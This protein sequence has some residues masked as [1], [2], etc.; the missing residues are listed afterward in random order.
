MTTRLVCRVADAALKYLN[1]LPYN[2]YDTFFALKVQNGLRGKGCN[3]VGC[4]LGTPLTAKLF[5][6]CQILSC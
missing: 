5:L 1:S 4:F 2:D 3:T 6:N